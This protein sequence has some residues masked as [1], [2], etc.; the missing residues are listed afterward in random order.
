M[1]AQAFTLL[2]IEKNCEDEPHRLIRHCDS[3]AEAFKKLRNHYENK[4][5]ADLGITVAGVVK[6]AYKEEGGKIEDHIRA[7]EEKWDKMAMTAT[8]KLKEENK[9]FGIW[10]AGL[11][12]CDNGKKEFLLM[13]F[14][15]TVKYNQLVQSLR[16]KSDHT[17]DD[18]VAN[19]RSYVPQ[20]AWKKRDNY[21]Q[22]KTKEDPITINRNAQQLT[23]RFGK[24]LD[25]SM[26]CE[27]CQK[28]KQWR[29]IGHT[30][31]ECKTKK[32]EKERNPTTTAK[33]VKLDLDDSDDEGVK[34]QR[35]FIRMIKAIQSQR[36]SG[37]YEYDTGAQ[38]HTTNERSR[39]L[40]ARL[41][42]GAGI[43]G[44]DG[45]TT[46]AELV[47]DIELPHNRQIV[48]LRNVLYHPSFS[49]LISGLRSTKHCSVLT[50]QDGKAVLSI[51]ERN[52][53]TMEDDETG[54]WI[55]PDDIHTNSTIAHVVV[56]D[57]SLDDRAK[58]QELH[59]RYGHISFRTLSSLPEVK[60]MDIPTNTFET[61]QCKACITGKSPK[62]A[63]IS[64]PK[65]PTGTR[66]TQPL[67][68][69]SCDLFGP[70]TKEWLGK[71]SVLTIID[72]YSRYCIAIPIRAKSD[73]RSKLQEVIITLDR[74]CNP[75]YKVQSIQADFGGEFHSDELSDWC[76]AYGIKRKPTVPYHHETNAS[77]ERLDRTLQDMA[78]TAMIAAKMKGMWG[79]AIQ[80]ATYTKNRI[81]HK[82]LKGLSPFEVLYNKSVD[83]A[84][85]RPFGQHVM[86]YIYKENREADKRWAPRSQ[87]ARIIGY[88]ETFGIYQ[89]ITATGKRIE[90][91]KNPMP[92]KESNLPTKG[93]TKE[94]TIQSEQSKEPVMK[95]PRRSTRSGR[96]LRPIDP[97]THKR[98]DTIKHMVNQVGHDE[99]H[100]TDQQARESTIAHEWAKARQI[101][102]EKLQKYGVYTVINF[103]PNNPVD[104][105]WVYDVKRDT[106][107]NIIR[108]RAR[109]VGRGF[110]QEHG[111][112]YEETYS[113][114]SRAETWKVLIVL[115]L[116]NNWEARQWD[117]K[118]AYLN[119]PLKHDVYV[120][121]INES[122]TTEFWK[123]HKALYGL[124]QAGHEW[125]NTMVEIMTQ[126]GL[127]QCIGDPGC[128]RNKKAIISTHVD[129]MLACGPSE[130]LNKIEQAI[131]QKVELDKLGLPTKLLGME[132][133]WTSDKKTVMLTQVNAIER[134][135][136]EHG[137]TN[138]VPTR[139]LPLQPE[140]YEAEEKKLQPAETT[141]YQ[142][143]VGSLLYIN[144]CTRPEI[145]VHIN[146]LGRRTSDASTETF[147]QPCSYYDILHQQKQRAYP[148]PKTKQE[149]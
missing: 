117:V 29:G 30:E 99:D 31:A 110:T 55:K 89:A 43:Q 62:P 44:H 119:A 51:Q 128:F 107:G 37:W 13:T 116:Q 94:P 141:K 72:N 75:T 14:P 46:R 126:A 100:P 8:S 109:K 3:A 114:M 122:G 148:L 102:R 88:T 18:I 25:M 90:T 61:M 130:E 5:V 1:R 145:S 138:K 111:I 105:K 47:G 32:R 35:M 113:Q 92:I 96:D 41:Y 144:R 127:T 22:G 7:F 101:E 69:I 6:L 147:K 24:P 10:L 71:S 52:V 129:D 36:H 133:T 80:W 39:L 78:R 33:P 115:A 85:L 146:L 106:A 137:I 12:Y 45:H 125:Y 15:D 4:M 11:A 16:N 76:K 67:E 139:S 17:Y 131:E 28:V 65:G 70:M 20:L 68:I 9:D 48:V 79:D 54:L 19:L 135:I 95:E 87:E 132:L 57:P 121:D 98:I 140:S 112:N 83:R 56:N 97:H 27:Y 124:K 74:C 49:N 73:A 84:N 104:T 64:K 53:Y 120:Q 34:V 134:L 142:S 50:R 21:G 77:I 143:L 40:N 60:K 42:T 2:T 86:T 82:A 123:L 108:Y 66:A 103:K 58:I 38:V 59:E 136:T 63:S 81:S 26:T 91:T 149:K 93:L 23:D 118:A